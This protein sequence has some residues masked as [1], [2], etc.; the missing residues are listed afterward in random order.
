VK[1]QPVVDKE[2]FRE[3]QT[4][5]RHFFHDIHKVRTEEIRTC[6]LGDAYVRFCSV[7]HR[8]HFLGLVFHFGQYSMTVVK[9]DE[10]DNS[11]SF[12][13]DREAWVM[14]VGF[15][16]DLKNYANIAKAIAGFGMLVY[17]H[18]PDNLARVVAKVYL[19]DDSKIPG[20]VKANAGLPPH[21]K[22]WTVPCYVLKQRVVPSRQPEEAYVTTG[23][24]HPIPP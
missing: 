16:E 4:A 21:G 1:L 5:L 11:R 3:V 2:D 19:N 23:P 15:P 12:N 24:L 8:E 9:R 20:S 17:W 22:S 14:L 10:S 13:L 7:L 18:E 6:P